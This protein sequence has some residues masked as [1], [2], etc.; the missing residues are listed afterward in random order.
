MHIHSYMIGTYTYPC[1]KLYV[2]DLRYQVN[3]E[4]RLRNTY[5]L[6]VG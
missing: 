1:S 2:Y 4:G 3:V 5:F 6:L